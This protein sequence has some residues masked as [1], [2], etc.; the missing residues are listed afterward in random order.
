MTAFLASGQPSAKSGTLAQD[1]TQDGHSAESRSTPVCIHPENPKYFLFRGKPL[2]LV[3]ASE[4]YGSVVNRPFNFPRYLAE[5]AAKKQ[6]MTRVFL[7]YRE[8]PTAR[9]PSATL[10]PESPLFL[11]PWTRTGPGRALDGEPMYDLGRWN[12]EY[13]ERLH[14]FLALASNLGIAVELTLFSNAYAE[15]IWA[16]NP[17]R[18]ENNLQGVGHVEW[19]DYTSRKDKRL[20]EWQSIYARKIIQETS[21]FDN[22]YYE[23]CNEPGG[24]LPHHASAEEVDD[25]Q[26]EMC[27]IVRDELRGLGRRH[28]LLGQDAVNY[29]PNYHQSF[30]RALSGSLFDAVVVHSN[31]ALIYRG[32]SYDLGRFMSKALKLSAFR[33]FFLASYPAPKPCISDEDNVATLYM[34]TQGWTIQRKRAWM[35]VMTGSHC[36]FIDFTVRVGVETGTRESRREIRTWMRNLSEFVQSVDII[37]SRPLPDWVESLPDHVLAATLAVSDKEYIAYLADAREATDAA[38]GQ[39]IGGRVFFNLPDGAFQ[40]SLYS[41]TSGEYSPAVALKGGRRASLELL[42]FQED[43]V[44]RAT[45]E[46]AP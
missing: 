13:F 22:V 10:C 42:P 32:K 43:M 29:T 16:L 8:L 2:V 37:H 4:H 28:M 25:W 5:A 45:R 17:L 14:N 26:R 20:S 39:P 36:D 27:S 41:P 11:A 21:K 46:K 38:A 44:I 9:N 40:V 18:A 15:N 31:S 3:A 19:P 24:G 34:D 33:D 23:L 12:P 30:D 6:T 7:L 1:A 35:A